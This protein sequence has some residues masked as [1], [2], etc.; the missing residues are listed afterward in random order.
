MTVVMDTC[1]VGK[2]YLAWYNVDDEF[3]R[4]LL[5]VWVSLHFKVIPLMLQLKK[6]LI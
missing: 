2:W 1:C 3:L 4:G 5:F 6:A